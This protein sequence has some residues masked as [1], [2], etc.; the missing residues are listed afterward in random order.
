MHMQCVNI[1]NMYGRRLGQHSAS[2][3][4]SDHITSHHIAD[5]TC[6]SR[7]L[8]REATSRASCGSRPITWVLAFTNSSAGL[9]SGRWEPITV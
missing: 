9:V 5:S 2:M 7:S 6:V 4:Q 1:I 3:L 8:R